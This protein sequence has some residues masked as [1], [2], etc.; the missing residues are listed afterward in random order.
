MCVLYRGLLLCVAAKFHADDV[1][2][3]VEIDEG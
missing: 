1:A 2:G 3:G